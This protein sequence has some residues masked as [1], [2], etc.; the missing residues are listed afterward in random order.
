M[1]KIIVV[2]CP[3]KYEEVI[4][5]FYKECVKHN[6][7]DKIYVATNS[8]K[9]FELGPECSIMQLKKDKQFATNILGALE[10]IDSE[11]V[12]MCCEDH[13]MIDDHDPK[14][15]DRAYDFME[16]TSNAG[17]LRLTTH[18]KVMYEDH[19][20]FAGKLSKKYKYYISLQPAVWRK[21]F[22]QAVLKH[23]EDAWQTET[24]GT[25]RAVKMKGWDTYCVNE[26]IFF[27]TNFFKSGKYL[28]HYFVDYANKHDLDIQSQYQVYDKRNGVKRIVDR[29]DYS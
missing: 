18:S 1:S 28:R 23:G 3:I 11:L 20:D 4:P 2:Q 14:M 22:L 12:T 5:I 25:R 16:K 27:A 8:T 7:F 10:T 24:T 17:M 15:F 6:I 29:G 19:G 9:K 21:S 26:T 13:V